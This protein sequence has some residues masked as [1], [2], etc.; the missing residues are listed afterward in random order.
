MNLLGFHRLLAARLLLLRGAVRLIF[1]GMFFYT[2]VQAQNNYNLN[3]MFGEYAGITFNGPNAGPVTGSAMSAPR[4]V[5]TISDGSANLLYYTNGLR[6][7][8]SDHQLIQ[9]GNNLAGS[10]NS[11]QSSLFVPYPEKP[12]DTY[13]FTT[14]ALGGQ[15]GLRYSLIRKDV[16]HTGMVL[17]NQKNTPLHTPVTE[18]LALA[19][20][21]NMKS[22]W[23]VAHEWGTNRFLA[24]HVND[25][26][27]DTVPVITSTGPVY[28][29]SLENSVGYMVVSW[30]D[31]LLALAVTGSNR[32]DLF[33]FDNLQG[34]PEF[35]YSINNI[36]QPYGVVFSGDQNL[37]YVSGLDGRIY[38]YN[39]TAPNISASVYQVAN[40][41]KLTGALQ[42]APN[43]VIYIAREQDPYLGFI[44][45]PNSNG[46][47]CYYV[48]QG[49]YL[50]GNISRAGLPPFIPKLELPS[51][52]DHNICEEDTVVY[53]PLFLQKADSFIFYF[54]DRTTNF[55]D[56]TTQLP[57]W[58]VFKILGYN[59]VELVYYMCGEE[60]TVTAKVCMTGI[61]SVNLGPDTAICENIMYGLSPFLNDV[62]CPMMPIDFLWSNGATSGYLE[63]FPPGT[64]TVT[65]TNACGSGSD[66][67]HITGLPVPP[68]SLGPDQTL[69][70]GDT[71][72]LMPLPTPDSL[73]WYDG[74][75][76][77]IKMITEEGNYFVTVTNEFNCKATASVLL[78]FL[79]PPADQWNMQD[80]TICI[81]HPMEL[82]AGTGFDSYL[83]QDGSSGTSFLVT[84][85]GWYHVAVT[86][87]CGSSSDSLYVFLEDC[88]LKLYVPNAFFPN[89]DGKNDEFRAYGQ[90]LEEFMMTIYTRW[91]EQVFFTENPEKGWN[92]WYRSKPAPGGVYVYHI[93]YRDATGKRHHLSGS[94]TLIR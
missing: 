44:G 55:Y 90:Y 52:P 6:I 86:N 20:H 41:G 27:L 59:K 64:Y 53:N 18:K 43:G 70:R 63:V 2:P 93:I 58:H 92:G 81:G 65:V 8:G 9:N 62:Y 74:T 39:L 68:V 84:D 66:T 67:I 48:E 91:G 30:E 11:T 34:T 45:A 32:V 4:G 73:V 76:D 35:L 28:S 60:H 85:S 1:L 5:A 17:H 38:Q 29:G 36:Y 88:G 13:L 77:L 15:M 7:W 16:T 78:A 14:D 22:Y 33:S 57:A 75:T 80:T 82:Y 40:T 3:W 87:I 21:C 69:C 31:D 47:S 71:A 19:R 46:I 72:L 42:M 24:Y 50:A 10:P 94:V 37:L 54:G 89:G 83:W 56:S 12:D 25:E 49:L 51:I 26:G 23:V 61:P 79:D